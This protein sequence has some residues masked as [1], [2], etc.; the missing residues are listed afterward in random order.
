MTIDPRSGT[1]AA[2]SGLLDAFTVVALTLG[3]VSTGIGLVR[4]TSQG[5]HTNVITDPFLLADLAEALTRL[6]GP[7]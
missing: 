5:W 1:R 6:N 4:I 7:R 2:L 3:V